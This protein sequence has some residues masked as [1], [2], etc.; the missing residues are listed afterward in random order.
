[1]EQR[2]GPR[3]KVRNQA[4]HFAKLAAMSGRTF[5]VP[6]YP[7]VPAATHRSVNPVL[8]QLWTSIA[9]D[10]P[11]A[12]L[13]DSAGATMALNL[14][15]SLPEQGTR[16]DATI[17]LS[18][19]LDLTLSNPEIDRLADRDPLLRSDHLRELALLYAGEDGMTSGAVNP[20]AAYLDGLGEVV[21]FTGTRDILNPDVRRFARLAN[22]EAGTNVHVNEVDHMI[23]DWMLMPTPEAKAAVGAIAGLLSPERIA[24]PS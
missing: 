9:S 24:V 7:L 3:R 13:G 4:G 1:M 14:M 23:H 19:T 5:I 17:L 6:I 22:A 2:H 8:Q 16:P 12:L 21:I 20:M 10:A 15:A 11:V 18:P